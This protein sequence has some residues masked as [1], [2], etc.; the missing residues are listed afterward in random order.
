M[1]RISR[2]QTTFEVAGEQYLATISH[3][4]HDPPIIV[5]G[6]YK[7]LK[8]IHTTRCTLT[9]GE[10]C[11]AE[12]ETLCSSK[13]P[14]YNWRKGIKLALTRAMEQLHL[15]KP[16]QSKFFAAFYSEN[17]KKEYGTHG[18]PTSV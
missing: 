13:E 1:P 5:M 10:T 16:T 4:H 11:K 18:H 14:K 2:S 17:R 12:G 9:Y 6:K 7:P 15:D 3:E 8:I